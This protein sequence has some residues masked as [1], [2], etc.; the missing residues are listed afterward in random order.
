MKILSINIRGKGGSSKRRGLS[1]LIK[2]EKVDLLYIEE[3]IRGM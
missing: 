2:K 1:E 3:S